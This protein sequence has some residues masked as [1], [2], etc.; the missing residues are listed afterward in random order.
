MIV[1]TVIFLYTYC[2]ALLYGGI[3]MTVKKAGL[4]AAQ[5]KIIAITAMTK[6]TILRGYFTPAIIRPG[7]CLYYT[8]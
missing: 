5:F 8:P 2:T 3:S 6:L 7:L 4:N 1:F